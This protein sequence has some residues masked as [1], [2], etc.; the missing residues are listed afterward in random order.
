MWP[1]CNALAKD[2]RWFNRK[3]GAELQRR[4][5]TM[6]VKSGDFLEMGSSVS[7]ANLRL[8]RLFGICADMNPNGNIGQCYGVI[9]SSTTQKLMRSMSFT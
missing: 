3:F 1:Q 4:L 2:S 7:Q 8:Y 5:K 9:L 6:Q